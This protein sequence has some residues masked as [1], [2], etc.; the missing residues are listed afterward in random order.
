MGKYTESAKESAKKKF[1]N[2]VFAKAAK[3]A[4][5]LR[6]SPSVWYLDSTNTYT[7]N[8]LK[9]GG[10]SLSELNVVEI[11]NQTVKCLRNKHPNLNVH[12]GTFSQ[13]FTASLDVSAIYLDGVGN[14]KT[15]EEFNVILNK[16]E[17]CNKTDS[18][19]F[20]IT[21]SSRIR[22][23]IKV[24]RW[25]KIKNTPQFI[26]HVEYKLKEV[27]PDV[28][29][30]HALGYKK[31]N[32]KRSQ[33]MMFCMFYINWCERVGA[34]FYPKEIIRKNIWCSKRKIYCDEVSWY[35]FADKKHNTLEP[36]GSIII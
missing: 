27:F 8:A 13:K 1:N 9:K 16:L 36:S 7:T 30:S 24:S 26:E 35:G 5:G 18:M 32:H 4:T 25:K 34:E 22:K 33:N 11:E 12:H 19:V 15:L 29:I 6:H 3:K 23:P 31:S 14:T 10:F 2:E 20:A 17:Q 28:Q 21:F